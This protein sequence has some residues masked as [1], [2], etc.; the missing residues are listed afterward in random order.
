VTWD[1]VGRCEG[2]EGVE[3]LGSVGCVCG[4][5]PVERV[6]VMDGRRGVLWD[7]RIREELKWSGVDWVVGAVAGC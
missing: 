4:E 7:G 1:V 2:G 3:V 5:G 6:G